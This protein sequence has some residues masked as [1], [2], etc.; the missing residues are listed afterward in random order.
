MPP[1]AIAREEGRR[2]FGSDPASY[3]R[4]R[5]G[6]PERVYEILV[7]RCGLRAGTSVLEIG[8][9]T[10][11]ATR[12]L[13]DLGADPLVAIEPNDDLARYLAH[14]LG[15]HV[16]IRVTSLEDAELRESSFDL[17]TAASSFHWVDEPVGLAAIWRSLRPDGWIALWWT[18]FGEGAGPDDF[19]RATSRLLDDLDSSPTKGEP[20]RPPHALDVEARIG[21][22][23]AT[24]FADV[25]HEL[26]HWDATWDTEGIRALYGTFSPILRLEPARRKDIL[27]EIAR[28]AARQFGGRVSRTLTTS[29]YTARKPPRD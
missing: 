19:I 12:R 1:D 20:G 27:D 5:P 7:V 29:L 13:L 21:A 26:V 4:A 25:S 11:Q 8:P 16:D 10:G 3:D 15:D 28:I 22:L 2:F 14:S 24:G 17:A 9:G 18:L 23:V 6:H